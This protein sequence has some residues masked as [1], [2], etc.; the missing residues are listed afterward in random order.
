M[1]K[2]SKKPSAKPASTRSSRSGVA[3]AKAAK[4]SPERARAPAAP[5]GR[6][7]QPAKNGRGRPPKRVFINVLVREI[8]ETFLHNDKAIFVMKVLGPLAPAS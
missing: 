5:R 6:A 7:A 2:A 1:P 3:A 4:A 8:R